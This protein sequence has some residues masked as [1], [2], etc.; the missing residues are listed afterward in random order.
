M[1]TRVPIG[2]DVWVFGSGYLVAAGRVVTARHVLAPDG[3]QP[4]VGQACQV[5]AWPWGPAQEW[6]RGQVVWLHPAADAAVVT[7]DALGTDL[8]PVAWGR[9]EESD[10]VPWTATGFPVAGLDDDDRREEVAFG[11]VAPGSLAS[12]GGLALTVESRSAM[13]E[14]GGGSGWAGLSGAAV[15]S[16]DLLIG[17]VTTDPHR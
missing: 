15:F 8:P 12:V 4:A 10:P 11:R 6:R 2:E 3:A 16:G 5:R 7:V 9:I 17:M 13:D 14:P 1:R